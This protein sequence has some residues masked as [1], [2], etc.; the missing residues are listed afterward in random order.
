MMHARKLQL[1][2]WRLSVPVVAC[3]LPGFALSRA[4]SKGKVNG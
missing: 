1:P 4:A 2:W 3:A